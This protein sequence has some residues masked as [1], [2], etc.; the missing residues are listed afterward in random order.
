MAVERPP[1]DPGGGV[2]LG[3]AA[4]LGTIAAGIGGIALAPHIASQVDSVISD[5]TSVLPSAVQQLVPSQG[6]RIYAVQAPMP[7]FD[8]ATYRLSVGGLVSN[9]A[10]LRWRDFAGLPGVQQVSTFHCVTGWTVR[11]VHWEGVRPKTLIDL[12]KPSPQARYVS[13]HSLEQPYVDQISM[14][15][16]LLPDV[17]LAR[18]MDGRPL[19]RAHGAPMRLVIPDMYGYKNVKWVHAISFDASQ[20]PGYWEV[21]GYDV[22]AWVGRSNGYG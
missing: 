3:R 12:V 1:A 6:W 16:F 17:L 13:F 10:A 21:R 5:A 7:T 15:E 18:R 4:F 2:P 14:E 11:N 22:D 8:P 9:P 19:T 20:S